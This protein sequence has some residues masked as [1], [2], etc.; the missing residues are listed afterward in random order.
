MFAVSSG[1]VFQNSGK[2]HCCVWI[3]KNCL[4]LCCPRPVCLVK[5][6]T[7]GKD[8]QFYIVNEKKNDRLAK[9]PRRVFQERQ[10]SHFFLRGTGHNSQHFFS[11]SSVLNVIKLTLIKSSPCAYPTHHTPKVRSWC[12]GDHCKL[13]GSQRSVSVALGG[14]NLSNCLIDSRLEEF[15]L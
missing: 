5:F 1:I 13:Q 8:D 6:L 12:W 14:H 7:R 9:D 4:L 10:W 2:H 3:W 11:C 15:M